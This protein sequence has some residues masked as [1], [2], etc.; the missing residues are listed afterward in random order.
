MRARNDII[1]ILF[2]LLPGMTVVSCSSSD[3]MGYDVVD[4]AVA[5]AQPIDLLVSVGERAMKNSQA[6]PV[7]RSGTSTF[8]GIELMVAI[9][10]HTNGNNTKV[11]VTDEPL[12]DLVGVDEGDIAKEYETE[13]YNTYYVDRCHLMTGTNRMLVYG[14]AKPAHTDQTYDPAVHGKLSNLPTIRTKT[15]NITFSLSSIR[16]ST[17]AHADANALAS[18][19]TTIANTPGWSTTED[20]TL[21]SHYKHFINADNEGGSG[22]MSGAAANIEAFVAELKTKLLERKAATTDDALKTLIDNIITKIDDKTTISSNTYPR[23]IGLPDGAAVMRWTID[24]NT[25]NGKFE[26]RTTT[27]HLD[28]INGINRYTYPAE[29]MFFTDSPIRTSAEEVQKATYQNNTNKE[30]DAFLDTYYKG[31]TAVNTNTKAVAVV[32]PLQYGVAQLK[33]TLTTMS[34]TLKDAKDETVAG[35]SMATLPMTG[36]IIGGQHTVGHDMKP[37]GAQTDVDG[38]FIY[39]STVDATNLATEGYKTSTLVL[40]SYDDEKVPVILEF[41]NNTGQAF[42]GKDGTVYPGTRFYLIG[43]IDPA[44]PTVTG[45]AE[46]CAGRVFTQDY[47]TT[48]TMNVT[49]LAKAY[50]CMPDLLAPRLEVGVQVVTKWIQA[51]TTNVAL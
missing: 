39:E 45:S 27:T 25:G 44:D 14:K 9:P 11:A 3:D 1:Y 20:P 12:I 42:T 50:T 33:L 24:Q 19:M 22:L 48:M 37:R 36:L 51:T 23:S 43:M 8:P 26:V 15:E 49:S 6:T 2:C 28:N 30:W 40:Q 29:M 41:E 5:T 13:K 16:E 34:A 35:A 38:R 46:E 4:S 7:T 10:F 47:T 32:N 18:Y 21:L 31:P 17:E